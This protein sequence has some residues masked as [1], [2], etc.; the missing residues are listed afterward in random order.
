MQVF[1]SFAELALV[2]HALPKTVEP[3]PPSNRARRDEMLLS[4]CAAC[5][6]QFYDSPFHRIRR[7][8][9]KQKYKDSCDY[10]CYRNG[11]DFV[12]TNIEKPRSR[13]RRRPVRKRA[14]LV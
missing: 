4:L 13:R 6:Q 9:R 14:A 3:L 2:A 5:A 10:C 12:V 8:D 7:A 11:W 1:H